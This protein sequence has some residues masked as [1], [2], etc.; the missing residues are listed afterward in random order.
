ML[1]QVMLAPAA[2]LAAALW[3]RRRG[4]HWTWSAAVAVAAYPFVGAL[5]YTPIVA[6]AIATVAGARWHGRDRRAGGDLARAAAQRTGP[7]HALHGAFA[8]RPEVL[9][10][11]GLLIGSDDRN[12]PVRIP[13]GDRGGSHTLVVGATGSGK[14]VTQCWIA[15]RAI[16]AGHGAVVIDPKGDALMRAQLA[17][18]AV[19]NGREFLEWTPDGP[20]TY[21]PYG[22]GCDGEIADKALAGEHYSE[23]HYQRQAQR[24]LGHAV[25]A[26]R[27]AGVA[28]TPQTLLEHLDPLVLEVLAR[29]LP[30]Q[31]ARELCGYLDSLT[32]RQARDLAGTRD[33]LAILAESDLGR[34]LDPAAGAR[35]FELLAAVRERAVVLFR[36]DADRRPLLAQMLAAAIVQDLLTTSA[37]LQS[38]PVPT[39]A[40]IDEFSA[41][42]S[43]R[44]ARL[45]GRARS[46]GISCLLG[47][48]ELSDLRAT[49][50][51]QLLEQVLGNVG[52]VIAHRQSVPDSAEL[53]AGI[54]GTRGAWITTE[55]M[56]AA[57]SRT[58]G[59]EYLIHPDRIK[60]LPRG[61]AAVVVPAA[62]SARVA[63][64]NHP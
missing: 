41:L 40:V 20:C 5:G 58:R 34:W 46:A 36:L 44:V 32:A 26:M 23:P 7:L 57:A 31:Q 27:L 11:A 9:D 63:R 64:I 49:R 16:D 33:R 18:A 45:L 28:V 21:N 50:N 42:A 3:L 59:R 15:A 6:A 47:T 54:A 10:A 13:L 14:T 48:Q 37:E 38:R 17:A 55:R 35:S 24:Y 19:R 43:E 62:G 22:H 53:V 30:E 52:A 60:A 25:R 1:L 8:G 29:G 56:G 2:G 4:L 51:E 61:V 39:V 12:A